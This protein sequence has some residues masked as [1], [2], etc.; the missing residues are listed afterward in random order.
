MGGQTTLK[1]L[2]LCCHVPKS[3]VM[4]LNLKAMPGALGWERVT[5][6]GGYTL[7][8]DAEGDE[9]LDGCDPNIGTSTE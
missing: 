3:G 9:R 6:Q 5:T 4:S 8:W 2:N 1:K 7:Y